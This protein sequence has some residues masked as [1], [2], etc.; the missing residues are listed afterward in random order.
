MTIS[1]NTRP[2]R[3]S[4]SLL[5][6]EADPGTDNGTPGT[7]S[8][9][10]AAGWSQTVCLHRSGRVLSPDGGRPGSSSTHIFKHE[11]DRERRR[12][13]GAKHGLERPLLDGVDAGGIHFRNLR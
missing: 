2:D 13:S 4:R 9:G 12:L 3:N 11:P 7:R 10:M 5:F 8:I 6:R 1:T